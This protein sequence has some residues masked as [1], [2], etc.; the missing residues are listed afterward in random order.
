VLP[1]HFG[2][3]A[4]R[5][6]TL[7]FAALAVAI[8]TWWASRLG[9]RRAWLI[10]LLMWFQP[11]FIELCWGV[12][13][14]TPFLLAWVAGLAALSAGRLGLSGLCFGMLPLIR[15]EG[16]ALLG[17]WAAVATIRTALGRQSWG[18]W[19]R[20]G[21]LAALPLAAYNI[22]AWMC[23]HEWP[24][25]VYFDAKPTDIYGRGSLWH[26]FPVSFLPAGPA[27]IL[28]AAIG[29][30][31][32]V[33]SWRRTWPLLSYPFYFALHSLIFWKGLFASGGYYHF[34]M[35]LAPGLAIVAAFGA[36]TL[37]EPRIRWRAWAGYGLLAACVLEG[38][39]MGHRL[40]SP[41]GFAHLGVGCDPVVAGLREALNWQAAH[42]PGTSPVI[43]RHVFAAYARDWWETP[44]RLA[45]DA[46]P[47][48][49]LPAGSIVIWEAKYSD[50]GGMPQD[51]FTA[52]GWR[53]LA[54]FQ[55]G[56]VKIW[57]K[58]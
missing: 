54:T 5:I 40:R 13:T 6:W 46:T 56:S 47:A 55:D 21:L 29:L 51:C 23:L 39:V 19:L 11:W 58:N 14:Q 25:R 45:L 33:G 38:L 27:A 18:E 15:H 48:A 9:V 30:P 26:F 53:R 37:L 1:A 34:L 17:L 7:G 32:C 4:A 10:P 42:Y 52:P 57:Q 24:S 2:L 41:A 22:S 44:E 31:A 16:I 12:L 35:P 49:R 20:A 43:C 28:L 8:T 3:T 36:D 50:L